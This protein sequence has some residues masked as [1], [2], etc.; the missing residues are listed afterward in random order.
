MPTWRCNIRNAVS[1]TGS[2][3][4]RSAAYPNRG[5]PIPGLEHDSRYSE[6]ILLRIE[7]GGY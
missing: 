6:K 5:T 4:P 2:S 1:D 7:Q 3:Q